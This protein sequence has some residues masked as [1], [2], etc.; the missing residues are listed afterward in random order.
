MAP[1]HRQAPLRVV[2]AQAVARKLVAASPMG[3]ASGFQRFSRSSSSV[4]S[5]PNISASPSV[6]SR[7]TPI[8]NVP[9]PV[10]TTP[11]EPVPVSLSLSAPA[12]AILTTASTK[13]LFKLFIQ[14]YMD[15]VQNQAQVPV[16]APAL[17]VLVEPKE[18]PLKSWFSDLY[19]GKLYL[20]SYLFCQQCKDYSDR[21]RANE[22]N[23]TPLATT[24]LLDGISTR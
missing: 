14:T 23:H 16:Q 5:E 2:A 1:S 8:A 6:S 24:F 13:K 9:A 10:L 18:Q 11:D 19:F 3:S 22:E 12:I 21:P 20:D 7:A 17:P 4:L 15:I